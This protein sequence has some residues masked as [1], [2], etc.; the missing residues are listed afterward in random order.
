MK[1]LYLAVLVFATSLTPVTANAATTVQQVGS[2]ASAIENI[3]SYN[4]RGHDRGGRHWQRGGYGNEHRGRVVY[5]NRGYYNRGN[6]NAWN[7]GWH[8]DR[9]YDWR[10]YRSYNRNYYR[11]VRYYAPYQNHSYNRVNIGFYMGNGFYGQRYWVNNPGYY[12]LPAAYGPYR[13]VRYYDDVLLIDL[14]NGYVVDTVH[15]FYW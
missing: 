10:S 7:R 2:S 4:G 8:N 5:N 12:R 3:Q 1:S 15:N 9:R 6:Y 13:W 11:P 14:R